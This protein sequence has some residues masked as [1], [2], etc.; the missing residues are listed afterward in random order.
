MLAPE[1]ACVYICVSEAQ[2]EDGGREKEKEKKSVGTGKGSDS[3]FCS[4][5]LAPIHPIN[6]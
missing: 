3:I 2:T 6:V 4:H 1:H 5:A